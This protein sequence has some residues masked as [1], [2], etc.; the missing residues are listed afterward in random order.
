M[1]P[2]ARVIRIGTRESALAVVQARLV[3]D[4]LRHNCPGIQA[5]LVTMKTTGDKILNKPL[6][7]VGGKG[8]FVK[9]LDKA[10]LE[11]RTDLSVHSLKDLPMELPQALP[12]IGYS[13]REDP[14]DALVLPQGVSH[15]NGEGI[16]GCASP[17]RIAQ[18]KRLYPKARTALIR[19]NVHTR[20]QKLDSGQYSATILA[21][22]GLR[23]LGL[24]QRIYRYF[25]TEE[26]IP[27]AGQGILAVQGRHG[28]DYSCLQG[29]FDA[30]A[31]ACALAERT[32]VRV[33]DGGCSSP[34]AAYAEI[35]AGHMRL[36]GLF[37]HPDGSGYWTGEIEGPASHAQSLAQSL[38]QRAKE[39]QK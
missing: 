14:R 9:E 26:M 1:N 33:L 34:I 28:K 36:K 2:I 17:R 13:R 23:R 30:D 10:L 12:I 27:A 11:G 25:S 32:F 19:G 18:L 31:A 5:E 24:E 35:Q 15:W 20:L 3:A 29:F 16:V 4:Y 39:E 22:A 21:A 7:A 37:C 38:A 8:L 6:Q